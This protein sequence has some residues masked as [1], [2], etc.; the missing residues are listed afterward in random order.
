MIRRLLALLAL[1]VLV[2]GCQNKGQAAGS[3]LQRT[4]LA[5]YAASTAYPGTPRN[6]EL[7][8]GAVLTDNGDIR[9]INFSNRAVNDIN[10][11]VNKEYVFRTPTIP[12]K[13]MVTLPR[14]SFFNT[15]GLDLTQEKAAVGL[16]QVQV[17][18][19]LVDVLGPASEK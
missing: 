13:S 12:P 3:D 8:L 19:R 18:D 15:Q 2:A 7:N 1:T 5:A 4:Q 10:V 17:A 11:W 14:S 16:I 6:D 9:L